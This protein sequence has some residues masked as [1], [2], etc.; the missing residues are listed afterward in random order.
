MSFLILA[1]WIYTHFFRNANDSYNK[2][3]LYLR[4]LGK[5]ATSCECGSEGQT[6]TAYYMWLCRNSILNFLR[7]PPY[8]TF[9]T[10][11]TPPRRQ[12][13]SEAS[14][15]SYYQYSLRVLHKA[16]SENWEHIQYH[17]HGE[18]I[19][20][21]LSPW[22]QNGSPDKFVLKKVTID[23]YE[24]QS[25]SAHESLWTSIPYY[26]MLRHTA[27]NCGER[28]VE[29]RISGYDW[30]LIGKAEAFEEKCLKSYFVSNKYHMRR[31]GI[32]RG[33][34]KSC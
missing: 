1:F 11:C 2:E 33:T 16:Y 32:Q 24:V 18:L 10:V 5:P 8:A 23:E 19:K 14:E 20:R 29:L 9:P 13:A 12:F 21:M 15:L 25:L 27:T 6:S 28:T 26:T 7:M 3:W 31:S 30:T 22:Q 17:I 34:N 4:L